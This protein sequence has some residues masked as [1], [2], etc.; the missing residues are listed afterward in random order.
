MN[1]KLFLKGIMVVGFTFIAIVIL[2]IPTKVN[3]SERKV[4][5]DSVT[6]KL[7]NPVLPDKMWVYHTK[8]GSVTTINDKYNVGDSILVTTIHI[9]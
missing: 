9:K 5:I 8:L 6:V 7:R 1:S 3:K 2:L 4:R